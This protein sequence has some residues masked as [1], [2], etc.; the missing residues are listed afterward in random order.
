VVNPIQHLVYAILPEQNAIAIL[1]PDQPQPIIAA[2][3]APQATDIIVSEDGA[4]LYVTHLTGEVSSLDARSG[5]LQARVEISGPGLTSMAQGNGLLYAINAPRKELIAYDPRA[6]AVVNRITLDRPPVALAWGP[7]TGTVYV[8]GAFNPLDA[9]S[10]PETPV[11]MNFDPL[12]GQQFGFVQLVTQGGQQ[13]QS[14]V[15]QAG[16]DPDLMNLNNN[17]VVNPFSEIVYLVNPYAGRL[18]VAAP[19]LFPYLSQTQAGSRAPR[20]DW[21]CQPGG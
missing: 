20:P 2:P 19:C 8:L 18:S 13:G 14:P 11:L 16:P 10:V 1:D 7:L 15:G 17:M 12:S 4:T 5:E 9:T 3:S 6:Q 21:L